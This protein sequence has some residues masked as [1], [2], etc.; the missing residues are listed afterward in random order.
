MRKI[1]MNNNKILLIGLIVIISIKCFAEDIDGPF[2]S[3]GLKLGYIIG[4]KRSFTLG[5]ELSAG[6]YKGPFIIGSV[7]GL[8]YCFQNKSKKEYIEFEGGTVFGGMSYGI[9]FNKNS[10]LKRIRFFT[11]MFSY[12]SYSYTFTIKQK[13][14]DAVIKSPFLPEHNQF[15]W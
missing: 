8:Q 9:E 4:S 13:E 14:I 5:M 2:V 6:G 10:I 12:L 3:P 7:L 1:L 11:G 15:V